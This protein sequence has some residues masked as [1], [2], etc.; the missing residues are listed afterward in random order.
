M[1]LRPSA[2]YTQLHQQAQSRIITWSQTRSRHKCKCPRHFSF[3]QVLKQQPD[4]TSCRQAIICQAQRMSS[5]SRSEG[6]RT[7]TQTCSAAALD[8]PSL[9]TP[10]ARIWMRRARARPASRPQPAMREA[11]QAR[12]HPTGTPTY[13]RCSQKGNACE[14]H[15]TSL[16]VRSPHQ[17]KVRGVQQPMLLQEGGTQNTAIDSAGSGNTT[18]QASHGGVCLQRRALR[19]QADAAAQRLPLTLE[20]H[21]G[22]PQQRLHLRIRHSSLCCCGFRSGL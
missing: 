21:V 16:R 2:G 6:G 19:E 10:Q 8:H 13:R 7:S 18:A 20:R 9:A 11:A 15:M 12:L 1:S 3:L 14:L 4:I 5:A 22:M 17:C